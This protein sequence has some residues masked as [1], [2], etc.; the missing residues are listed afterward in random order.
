V[1]VERGENIGQTLT[2][3]NVVRKFRPIAMWKGRPLSLDLPKSEMAQT[4]A[5][6]CAVLLQIEERDGRPGPIL[7]AATVAWSE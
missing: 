1:A 2:Y 6:R 3:N 4:G 7:G 5:E